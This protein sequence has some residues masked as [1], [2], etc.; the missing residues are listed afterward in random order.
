MEFEWDENKNRD[1]IKKHDIDFEDAIPVFFDEKAVSY[2][3][4]RYVYED[5]QRMIVISSLIK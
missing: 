5:G 4:D 3:D 1:N 2:E